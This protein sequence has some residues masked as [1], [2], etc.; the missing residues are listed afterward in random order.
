VATLGTLAI[1]VVTD[2]F[3]AMAGQ[4]AESMGLVVFL[5]NQCDLLGLPTDGD[6]VTDERVAMHPYWQEW[7]AEAERAV[8]FADLLAR[9]GFT[10]RQVR[11]IEQ[12][13]VLFA[14]LIRKV[15]DDPSLG[16]DETQRQTGR[17]LAAAQLR[18]VAGSDQP[19]RE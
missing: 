9:A 1:P 17:R 2:P 11:V 8:R 10:E 3:D 14:D 13:A 12:Q 15:L 18:L 7:R 16:L 6:L 4:L 19:S 5:R